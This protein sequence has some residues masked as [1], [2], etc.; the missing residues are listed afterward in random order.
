MAGSKQAK[1][2]SKNQKQDVGDAVGDLGTTVAEVGGEAKDQVVNLTEQVRQQATEQVMSQKE[3]VVDTLD[4]VALL[5]HQAGE[6][7]HQ[8]DKAL[9]ATYVD[10][11]AT[12]VG[13]L[14]ET[15][16]EQD[17]KQL[18]QSTTDFAR[19]EPMLFVGGAL[20]AGFLGA[21][22]FRSSSQQPKED[23]STTSSS[24]IDSN[25]SELPPYDNDQPGYT[26]AEADMGTELLPDTSLESGV[27]PETSGFLED[28]E[29]AVLEAGD[30]DAIP[31]AELDDLTS[32]E[33]L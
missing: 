30:V 2:S 1:G 12:Q 7:A 13:Q 28:Y 17:V 32:P 26:S 15:V 8:Q 5:L 19:R 21:R 16:G 11:A 9:L 29:A 25:A 31:E 22:F 18:M 10:K 20:A 23:Q 4:T 24:A 14:S 6:H 33:Q 27:T 3:R